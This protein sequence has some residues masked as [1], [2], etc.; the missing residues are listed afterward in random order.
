LNSIM[1]SSKWG[2]SRSAVGSA[3]EIHGDA[4]QHEMPPYSQTDQV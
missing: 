4:I 3:N 1:R 2:S